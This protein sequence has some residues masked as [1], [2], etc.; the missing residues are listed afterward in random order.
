MINQKSEA[1][2]QTNQDFAFAAEAALQLLAPLC[3]G[4]RLLVEHTMLNVF[5]IGSRPQNH[6]IT[7]PVDA[8]VGRDTL[9]FSRTQVLIQLVSHVLPPSTEKAC[10]QRQESSLISDQR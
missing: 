6:I 10:S 5:W 2:L 1:L 7:G 4:L 3:Q 8:D 9:Y